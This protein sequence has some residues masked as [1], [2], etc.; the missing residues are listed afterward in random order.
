MCDFYLSSMLEDEIYVKNL[1][2]AEEMKRNIWWMI[3]NTSHE[4]IYKVFF[5]VLTRCEACLWAAGCHFKHILCFNVKTPISDGK[6]PQFAVASGKNGL[7]FL[8]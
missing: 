1:H 4:E 2:T 8:T 6:Y 3:L 5:S 7:Q